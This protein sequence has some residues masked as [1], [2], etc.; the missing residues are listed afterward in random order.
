MKATVRVTG[1][2]AKSAQVMASMNKLVKVEQ[3]SK[4]MEAMSRE[5]E[6]VGAR[7]LVRTNAFL[8]CRQD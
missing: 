8:M 6:K 3:I 2:M 4:T 1:T 7:G 5:M